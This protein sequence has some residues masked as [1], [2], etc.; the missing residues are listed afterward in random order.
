MY[1][2]FLDADGELIAA[3]A[4]MG[5]QEDLT[6]QLLQQRVQIDEAVKSSLVRVPP[7][8]LPETIGVAPALGSNGW[9][10]PG[11]TT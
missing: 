9:A 4:D 1:N 11:E 6:P 3:V 8:G 10:G 2:A 7:P 5:I